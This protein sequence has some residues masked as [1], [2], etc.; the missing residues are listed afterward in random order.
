MPFYTPTPPIFHALESTPKEHRYAVSYFGLF[1][2]ATYKHTNSLVLLIAMLRHARRFDLL[3]VSIPI[4]YT[5]NQ[6][7]TRQLTRFNPGIIHKL[8]CVTNV[9]KYARSLFLRDTLILCSS[10]YTNR[11][12][13]Q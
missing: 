8:L 4:G 5:K 13:Y 3:L 1:V 7:G 10:L 11:K 2:T 12:I 9:C 6:F